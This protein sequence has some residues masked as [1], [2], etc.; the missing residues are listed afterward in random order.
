ME[1]PMT[2][3][4]QKP[5]DNSSPSVPPTSA[6]QKSE[7]DPVPYDRELRVQKQRQYGAKVLA[8]TDSFR[9]NL[10]FVGVD[11]L[12]QLY[13]LRSDIDEIRSAVPD[14]EKRSELTLPL[15]DQYFRTVKSLEAVLKLSQEQ[16]KEKQKK[17]M[18]PPTPPQSA[19]VSPEFAP[20]Q[21]ASPTTRPV[22]RSAK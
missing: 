4:N 10:D 20:E 14:P 18:R 1:V 21:T 19:E 5:Q 15:S 16:P 2:P 7:T 12:A 22:P 3:G 11:L 13:Y 17:A 9:A 6:N 8:Q